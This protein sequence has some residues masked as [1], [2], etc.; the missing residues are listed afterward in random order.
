MIADLASSRETLVNSTT[1]STFQS[2]ILSFSLGAMR[3]GGRGQQVKPFKTRSGEG[4]GG[5][6]GGRSIKITQGT[7]A[8]PGIDERSDG[9]SKAI[10]SR[11]VQIST[12]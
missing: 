1:W 7:E 5:R 10:S 4:E 2:S 12:P 11:I 3:R 8:N 6:I 9:Q